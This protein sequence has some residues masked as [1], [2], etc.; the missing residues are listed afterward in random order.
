MPSKVQFGIKN[1]HYAVMQ[2]DG[3]YA[4]PVAVNGTV[5]INLT[6]V[7]EMEPFYADN[8]LYYQSIGNQGYSGDIEIARVPD[9]MY[10]DIFGVSTDGNGIQTEDATA[11]PKAVALMF[12]ID[13]DVAKRCYV[14]YNVTLGRPPVNSST[15][16]ESKT[17]QTVSID[18]TAAP[19]A[20]GVVL[21][22]TGDNTFESVKTLWYTLVYENGNIIGVKK[23]TVGA[24]SFSVQTSLSQGDT[25]Y[26]KINDTLPA[27]GEEY[28]DL[29]GW[30]SV[31]VALGGGITG[32]GDE[33]DT[34]GVITVDSDGKVN[35]VGE[36]VL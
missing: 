18:L 13:G 34:V 21:A 8:V 19:L 35:A 4:A 9:A 33:G 14:L 15:I 20:S 22:K 6:P 7:G 25:A 1:L 3:S 30:T 32:T 31:T 10:T 24:G 36:T 5:S 11:E 2:S 28:S 27:I 29:V 17:P 26:Y 16:N 23:G 12:E